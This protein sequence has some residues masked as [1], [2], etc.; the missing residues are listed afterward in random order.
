MPREALNTRASKPG[1]NRGSKFD[2]QLFGPH[3][4]FLRVRN[5][6]RSNLVHDIGG[7]IAQHA[8]GADVENLDDTLGIGGDTGEVG[9]IENR[10]LQGSGLEKRL[11]RMLVS[12]VVGYLGDHEFC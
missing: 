10:T 7:R 2:T 9:A 8:L 5:V 1:G 3:D 12:G 11:F 4:D 6:G